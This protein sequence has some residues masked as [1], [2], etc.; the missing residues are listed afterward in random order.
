LVDEKCIGLQTT[1]LGGEEDLENQMGLA[2]DGAQDGESGENG[3]REYRVTSD[4]NV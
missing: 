4:A 1:K 3:G 2:E